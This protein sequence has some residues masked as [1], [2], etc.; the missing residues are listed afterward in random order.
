M[1]TS[2]TYGHAPATPAPD[3]LYAFELQYASGGSDF[4]IIISSSREAAKQEL[5]ACTLAGIKAILIT[6][7]P[8][9]RELILSHY[10]GIAVFTTEFSSN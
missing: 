5:E 6:D 7:Q 4:G 8:H 2:T 10:R 1:T 3:Q 9:V